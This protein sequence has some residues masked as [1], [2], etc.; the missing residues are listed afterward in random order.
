VRRQYP[1]KSDALLLEELVVDD[2]GQRVVL[3]DDFN[4]QPLLILTRGLKLQFASRAVGILVI[5]GAPQRDEF[6]RLT[7]P[8]ASH[9]TKGWRFESKAFGPERTLAEP[10]AELET[11]R[12]RLPAFFPQRYHTRRIWPW[13]LPSAGASRS[14][15]RGRAILPAGPR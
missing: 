2:F 5:N 6:A 1:G 3:S 4:R 10:T 12:N 11:C 7:P 8:R 15:R 14:S 9:T 13:S